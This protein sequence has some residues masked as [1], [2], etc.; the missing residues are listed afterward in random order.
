MLVRFEAADV[1]P[2]LA[3]DG[4]QLVV[5]ARD[6]HRHAWEREAIDALTPRAPD[7]IV[8]EIGLPHWRPPWR[9]DVRRDLRRRP[10]ECAKRLPSGYTRPSD[11]GWSS[12]VARRAHNPEVA[13][14]NPAPATEKPR[15]RGFSSLLACCRRGREFPTGMARSTHC[16][17]KELISRRFLGGRHFAA[18]KGLG[19]EIRVNGKH[20]EVVLTTVRCTSCGNEF[21]IRSARP[22]LVVDVCA[23]CHPAYTGVEREV[24]RGSRIER[25]ERRRIRAATA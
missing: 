3:L 18:L 20:P 25:F 6:A 16:A 4:R 23:N 7:A 5:I 1:D 2:D 19:K 13:G 21:T 17:R 24:V 12:L 8:V 9:G 14:S 10:R 15:K 22:E 11:A